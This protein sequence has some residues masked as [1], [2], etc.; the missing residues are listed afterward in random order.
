MLQ[1]L[2]L[3]SAAAAS[4]RR[5][6]HPPHPPKGDMWQPLRDLLESWEL[7]ENYAVTIGNASGQLFKYEGG[8]MT[9][10]TLI[11][12]GSTSK[13]PSAL[14]F[15]GLVADGTF[16]SLDSK[17]SDYLPWWTTDPA[18]DRSLVTI[19]MLLSFTSGFGDGDPGLEGNTRAAREWRKANGR[20]EAQQITLATHGPADPAPC[21]ALLGN[22]SA[23]VRSIYDTVE[24]IGTPGQVYSYNSNH[25]AIAA[26]M[27][28]AATGLD[29]HAVI[30]KY[31]LVPF[32]MTSSSYLGRAP[33]FG[34]GL[35]TTGR[36]YDTFL[37]KVL[38]RQVLP[39]SI[40]DESETDQT[41]FMSDRYSL[42]GDYGF[43][44][45]LMCFDS[46]DGFTSDCAQQQNH[47]DPGAFGF[48][49]ILDRKNGYY[50]QVVAAE[51][52]PTGNYPLSGIPEYLAVAIKPHVDA[53]LSPNPPNRRV[54]SHHALLS[55]SIADVNYCLHCKLHPS[56]CG[57]DPH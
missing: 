43:G 27:A 9:I 1:V 28:V 10:D 22:T 16:A 19:R 33:D 21:N 38:T 40:Y 6:Q 12:T 41:P 49:P 25:F 51:L 20:G 37:S 24:L 5:L 18:D 8:K 34:A 53:I 26:G 44:H 56:D 32:N 35:R 17:V 30:S 13:W 52:P 55:L 48:I 4:P 57:P 2:L 11:P 7:T 45:F 23:C 39:R 3:V 50:V 29:I 47:I 31:L 14:M 54:H 42:Y 46:V 15:A 36:D